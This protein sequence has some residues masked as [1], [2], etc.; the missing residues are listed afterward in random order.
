VGRPPGRRNG[1]AR[2]S[3]PSSIWE[4]APR[5]EPTQV[6]TTRRYFGDSL[7]GSRGLTWQD[8]CP[9]VVLEG[10]VTGRP[11]GATG[12]GGITDMLVDG[13]SGLLGP[14]PQG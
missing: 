4:S 12:I 1:F 6:V 9:T 7:Y 11:V 14:L 5:R 10:M 2:G 13:E 3:H 8:A